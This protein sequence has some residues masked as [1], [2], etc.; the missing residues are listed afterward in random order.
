MRYLP[1]GIIGVLAVAIFAAAMSSLD[2]ALNSLSAASYKDI[3]QR[4][5]QPQNSHNALKTS[6]ILTVFWGI[7]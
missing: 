2:S 6:K 4:Y 3:Y 1:H 7:F 5:F